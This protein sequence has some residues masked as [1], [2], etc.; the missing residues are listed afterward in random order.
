MLAGG[1]IAVRIASTSYAQLT[2]SY[3]N[4]IKDNISGTVSPTMIDF[5]QEKFFAF[6]FKD[7]VHST[8]FYAIDSHLIKQAA[9]TILLV[10]FCLTFLSFL[11]HIVYA[12]RYRYSWHRLSTSV[13]VF[14]SFLIQTNG[15]LSLFR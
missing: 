9:Q 12:F 6:V 15:H 10:I 5:E 1:F 3:P 11:A 14:H 7:P 4:N 8:S 2:D 13:T